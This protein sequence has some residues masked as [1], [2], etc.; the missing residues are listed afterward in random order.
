MTA[1]ADPAMSETAR[2]T[3]T[4]SDVIEILDVVES[5][6]IPVWLDGG[7]GVDALLREQ[8]R[9]HADLD[10]VVRADDIRVMEDVLAAHGFSVLRVD[11]PFNSVLVDGR[12]RQ[13]DYHLVDLDVTR[14]T[15]DGTEVYGPRG[16]AYRVGCL[17]GV[18]EVGGREVRCCTAAY[19]AMS[20]AQGYEPDDDDYRD[21]LAL[22]RRFGTPLLPPF[23]AWPGA[24]R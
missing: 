22:H 17:D 12:A 13:V 9:A 14:R 24:S 19:Q 8:T 18:G 11:G 7:W 1:D 10:I 21:V 16:L 23:D 15:D 20:H 5:S 3:F 2:V 6:G 4:A